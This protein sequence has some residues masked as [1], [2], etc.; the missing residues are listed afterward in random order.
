[1]KIQHTVIAP[2]KPA[3]GH[4]TYLGDA[5]LSRPLPRIDHEHVKR[6]LE[7]RQKLAIDEGFHVAA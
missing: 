1:M 4:R 3:L 5:H 2:R 7:A 6:V